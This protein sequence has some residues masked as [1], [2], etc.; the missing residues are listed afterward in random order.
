MKM[1]FIGDSLVSCTNETLANTW[2]DIASKKMGFE[3]V[4]NAAGGKLTLVMWGMFKMDVVD[5][6][7]DGVVPVLRHERHP[8]GRTHELH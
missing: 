3:V 2:Y 8:A 4:N 1:A 7:A 5:E 6:K